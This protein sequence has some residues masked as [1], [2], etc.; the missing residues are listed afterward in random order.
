MQLRVQIG[1]KGWY[2]KNCYFRAE[3]LNLSNL[4]IV[5][6]RLTIEL[7]LNAHNILQYKQDYSTDFR[8]HSVRFFT[9]IF[10]DFMMK[11]FIEDFWFSNRICINGNECF[12]SRETFSNSF[13]FISICLISAQLYSSTLQNRNKNNPELL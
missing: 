1:L 2:L 3:I 5:H 6:N 9:K 13:C 10:L 8:L 11:T 7:I 12:V 4:N